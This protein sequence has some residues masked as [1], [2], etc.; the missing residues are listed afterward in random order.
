MGEW[1]IGTVD[2]GIVEVI[3]DGKVYKHPSDEFTL[4]QGEQ[5]ERGDIARSLAHD[6]PTISGHNVPAD[7]STGTS[8]LEYVETPKKK[9]KKKSKKKKA[10]V[11]Q[12]KPKLVV[13]GNEQQGSPA[14]YGLGIPNLFRLPA[15]ADGVLPTIDE[16]EEEEDPIKGQDQPSK[17][18]KKRIRQKKKDETTMEEVRPGE[19]SG[20]RG[21]EIGVYLSENGKS[22]DAAQAHAR[23]CY[24]RWAVCLDGRSESHGSH[25][26]TGAC[27]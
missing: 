14:V 25:R 21:G 4:L 20:S 26:L 8:E 9:K 27:S 5:T 1:I 7:D 17:K 3:I 2:D 10:A 6:M 22:D 15:D 11:G 24:A 23:S 13:I 12:E 18:I 16:A 19:F